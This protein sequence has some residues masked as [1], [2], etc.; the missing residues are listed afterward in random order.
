MVNPAGTT[1]QAFA[2]QPGIATGVDYTAARTEAVQPRQAPAAASQN[3][4]QRPL[5]SRDD[6]PR[7]SQD[8]KRGGT[9][10]VK[11]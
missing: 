2:A 10:D 3:T 6:Q 1:G 4:G 5:E 8:G 7:P 11:A 9:V